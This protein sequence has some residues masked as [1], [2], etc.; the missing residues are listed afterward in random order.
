MRFIAFLIITLAIA[1]SASAKGLDPSLLAEAKDA[2]ATYDDE[3]GEAELMI[4]VDYGLRSDE[5]RLFV[6]DLITGEV[7]AFR[8][9]HGLG[10][11]RDHDG[12]LEKFS[13]VPGSSA[14][15]RGAFRV[16]EE[17]YGQHGRS[18]RLDGLEEGNANARPRAIV[19]HAAWYA[20]RTFLTE[21]GKLGRSNGCVVLSEG[22]RDTVFA[23]LPEGALLYI[24]SSKE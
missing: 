15:P 20:E 4:V 19:I 10:S 3:V 2:L 22:D 14:S 7:R 13:S 16:A 12:F 6:V 23:R 8:A 9:A 18:R 24:G 5:E 17:Y 11:D 1:G 21:H